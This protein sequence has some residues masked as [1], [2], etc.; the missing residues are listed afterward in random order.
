MSNEEQ[1]S[2]QSGLTPSEE[3][4]TAHL[5]AAWNAWVQ[6]PD[7]ITTEEM[8]RFRRGIREAQETLAA[9]ALHRAYAEYWT[10]PQG[11]AGGNT[12][13]HAAQIV[14]SLAG[15][16]IGHEAA[17]LAAGAIRVSQDADPKQIA[18]IVLG[19]IDQRMRSRT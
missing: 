12:Y 8:Q 7:V 15:V 13:E 4:V 2:K 18:D 19:A 5:V 11:P 14:E 10:D 17:R 9:R 6:Q 16:Q 1:I 3:Q